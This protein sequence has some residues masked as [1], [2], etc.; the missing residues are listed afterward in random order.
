MLRIGVLALSLV[1]CTSVSFAA[2]QVVRTAPGSVTGVLSY[3]AGQYWLQSG[4]EALCVMVDAPDEAALEPL[5]DARVAFTGP[6]QVWSDKSRCIVVGPDFPQPATRVSTVSH[7][8]VVIGAHGQPDLD[9]CLS[10]GATASAVAVRLAPDAGAAASVQVP[11]G[12]QVYLCGASA[13]GRWES[14]VVPP[15]SGADCGVSRAVPAPRPYTGT[16]TSGWVPAD[17]VQVIAG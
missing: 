2:T 1:A 11:A 10:V 15:R 4:K 3:A 13:D 12:Q 9:A 7:V 5:V 6:I 17:Q 8:P 14:V 16:C